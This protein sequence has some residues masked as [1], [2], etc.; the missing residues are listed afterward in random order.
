MSSSSSTWLRPM[1]ISWLIGGTTLFTVNT[2][3]GVLI[4]VTMQ[5]RNIT[6]LLIGAMITVDAIYGLAQ[7]SSGI[8]SLQI[9]SNENGI[10]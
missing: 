1:G 3:A 2:I 4:L 8:Y 5:R 9:D 7:M 6:F 10:L